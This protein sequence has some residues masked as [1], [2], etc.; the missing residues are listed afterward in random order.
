M[1]FDGELYKYYVSALDESGYGLPLV[2]EKDLTTDS[3]E[4]DTNKMAI[5]TVSYKEIIKTTDGKFDTTVATMKH[6]NHTGNIVK[7]NIVYS[8]YEVGDI[9]QLI[10]GS[11]WFSISKSDMENERI[12]LVSY[13]GMSLSNHGVQ[14]STNPTIKFHVNQQNPA[15]YD[16]NASIYSVAQSIVSGTQV[17]LVERGINV[18]GATI[19]MPEIADF[20]CTIDICRPKWFKGDGNLPF[21]TIDTEGEYV[22]TMG[23]DGIGR[24]NTEIT[25]YGIR[26]VVKDLLKSNIDKQATKAL[27]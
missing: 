6:I 1:I 9:I 3:I 22:L 19:K 26:I 2:Y 7:V 16:S 8:E 10:D 24:A 15:K 12:T 5:S 13:Y 18:K 27:N 14:D 11:K 25:G 21:W 23:T 20:N 17:K 4:T